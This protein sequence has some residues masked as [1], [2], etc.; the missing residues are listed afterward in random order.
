MLILESEPE[1]RRNLTTLLRPEKLHALAA[2]N[3]RIGEELAKKEKPDLILSE[4][5]MPELYWRKR[6]LQ[7]VSAAQHTFVTCFQNPVG[8]SSEFAS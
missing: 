1:M 4:M 3:G 2:E 8:F 5:V 6:L 7:N